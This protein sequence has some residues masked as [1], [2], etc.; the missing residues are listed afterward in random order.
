MIKVAMMLTL[1]LLLSACGGGGSSNVRPDAPDPNLT[2]PVEPEPTERAEPEP[3][4]PEPAE[5]EPAEPEPAEPEP[6]E[7]E[8]V[9][10]EPVEPELV[11]HKPSDYQYQYSMIN[12][13]PV[14]EAG[15]TGSG[16][17]VGVVDSG[18]T[19]GHEEFEGRI[20][21]ALNYNSFDGSS[22]VV[23]QHGHGSLVAS[24]VA[25]ATLGVA[26][27]AELIVVKANDESTANAWHDDIL[28]GIRY[29]VENGASVVNASFALMG[30]YPNTEANRDAWAAVDAHD[31]VVVVAAG[32]QSEEVSQEHYYRYTIENPD[33]DIANVFRDEM[34]NDQ[35]IMVGSIDDKGEPSFFSNIPG[36]DEYV[37]SR[38][39]VAPG[40]FLAG[41]GLE[42]G[43]YAEMSGTSMAA[44]IVSGVAALIRDRWPHLS[45]EDTA[46]ILL[47]TAD[48]SFSPYYDSNY[49]GVNRDVNCGLFYFGQGRV[50]A[51][52]AVLPVGEPVLPTQQANVAEALASETGALKGSILKTSE[53][54]R[55]AG[56][57]IREALSGV[58]VFDKYGRDFKADLSNRVI[59][60]K[61][62]LSLAH[63]VEQA[64][65]ELALE[66]QLRTLSQNGVTGSALYGSTGL[67]Y[68]S[69]SRGDLS[70]MHMRD[71]RNALAKVNMPNGVNTLTYSGEEGILILYDA[72]SGVRAQK[73]LLPGISLE[74][75]H[76]EATSDNLFTEKGASLASSR[77]KLSLKASENVTLNLMSGQHVESEN[78]LGLESAGA[79]ALGQGARTRTFGLSTE[80]ALA[81][82]FTAFG[83]VEQGETETRVADNS[84]FRDK[85]RLAI[86]SVG[87]GVTWA[88]EETRMGLV[89]S[90][91]MHISD[92][93][94]TLSLPVGREQD[95][96]VVYQR[97]SVD[98]ASNRVE[99]NV[100]FFVEKQVSKR[101]SLNTNILYQ[102][103]PG[104]VAGHDSAAML[105][106]KAQ[107]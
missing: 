98:M 25:G 97:V 28:E 89:A 70:I 9:E 30:V 45:A 10:P 95:G 36:E 100:E 56:A 5:P 62:S 76:W 59:D 66:N 83:H 23:D 90:Q 19:A 88:G 63:R 106:I 41:A 101:M 51:E 65:G 105:G 64:V 29:T 4:E 1:A 15:Y 47:D 54:T 85:S 14:H 87:L 99:Q 86:Q 27:N 74:I 40:E 11:V 12:L 68:V 24:L 82:G 67:D 91:P 72:A 71:T 2:D 81:G 33:K 75:S 3:V 49:C 80:I 84:M 103:N 58:A 18:I 42:A 69:I 16:V 79:F 35:F 38:W 44:P 32:N 94:A 73:T 61:A 22:D 34:I 39:L 60:G 17:V 8:P 7:P 55:V 92:G 57:Q 20:L 46:F 96:S 78:I 43:E 6:V 31:A 102:K 104:Q 48:Q 50:D 52:A 77:A 21:N 13:D 107:F 37:Y 93:S 53:M 26:P